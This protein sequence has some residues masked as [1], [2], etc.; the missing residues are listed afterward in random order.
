MPSRMSGPLVAAGLV[1]MWSS[2]FVGAELGTREA[3]ADTLLMWRFLVAAALLGGVRLLLRAAR[4]NRARASRR[5]PWRSSPRSDCSHR[6]STSAPS[7]GRS[8]SAYRR[9]HPHSSPPSSRSPPEHSPGGCSARR[10]PAA[11]GRGSRWASRGSPWSCGTTGLPLRRTARGLPASFAG[12][13][14]LLAASFLERRARHRVPAADALPLHCVVS[15][16]LFTALAAFAGTDGWSR[17]PPGSSGW[18]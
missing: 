14:G 15:A 13:A 7:S 12:M 8:A 9:G 3:S 5:A 2:G 10:S 16:L 18:P 17:P 1:L 11:S 4:G 6:A